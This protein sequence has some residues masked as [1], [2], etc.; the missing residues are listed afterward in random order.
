MQSRLS[1]RQASRPSSPGQFFLKEKAK[2]VPSSCMLSVFSGVPQSE[3]S[4]DAVMMRSKAQAS[5]CN[6][7]VKDNIKVFACNCD[8]LAHAT[9]D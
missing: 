4:A 5:I 3:E 6:V 8:S 9:T 7:V 2:K 1:H